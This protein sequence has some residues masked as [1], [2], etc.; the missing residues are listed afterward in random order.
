M[1]E[2]C[3]VGS[4]PRKAYEDIFRGLKEMSTVLNIFRDP[5]NKERGFTLLEIFCL[6]ICNILNPQ[7]KC[8]IV[9]DYDPDRDKVKF[10]TE[11]DI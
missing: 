11:R 3:S 7:N 8:R 9:I 1:T 10:Y 2:K 5:G 4:F 6:E